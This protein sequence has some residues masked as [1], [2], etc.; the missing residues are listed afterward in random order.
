MA[1]NVPPLVPPR[2]PGAETSVFAPGDRP[3]HNYSRD[4]RFISSGMFASLVSALNRTA[5]TFADRMCADSAQV[6][7]LDRIGLSEAQGGWAYERTDPHAVG[8]A[9]ECAAGILRSHRA[10][11]SGATVGTRERTGDTRAAA[12]GA[13][14]ALEL[15]RRPRVAAAGG[16]AAFSGGSRAPRADLRKSGARGPIAHY[17]FPFQRAPAADARRKSA[18]APA[19]GERAARVPGGRERIHGRERRA[20]GDVAGR[21]RDHTGLDLARPRQ[22]RRR[23]GDLARRARRADREP[24]RHELCRGRRINR[25]PRGAS[26]ARLRGALRRSAASRLPPPFRFPVVSPAEL[27]LRAGA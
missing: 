7:T 5:P 18:R 14:G 9:A 27:S 13:A 24:V 26:R 3:S 19:H 17:R 21:F 25:D 15:F 11:E 16:R 2:W 8:R 22:R 20:H 6:Y 4:C 23:S 10:A 1:A 12:G